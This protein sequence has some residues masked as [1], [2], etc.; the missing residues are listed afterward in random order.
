MAK[1][2]SDVWKG[3][4]GWCCCGDEKDSIGQGENYVFA[5]HNALHRLQD[6]VY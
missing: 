4:G 5:H 3:A 2:I 6:G 1:Y